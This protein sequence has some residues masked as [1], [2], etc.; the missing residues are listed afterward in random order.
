VDDAGHKTSAGFLPMLAGV[1]SEV[2][3]DRLV[4]HLTCPAE[5][6][7]LH[8][9]PSLSAD[10]PRY[11]DRGA[12]RRGSVYPQDNYAIVKGLERYRRDA[13]ALRVA[14]NH[15]TTVSHVFKETQALWENYA[16]DYIEPGSIAHPDEPLAALSAIA[17]LLET[18]FGFRVDAPQ[19]ALHWRPHLRETHGVEGLRVGGARVSAHVVEHMGQLTARLTTSEPLRLHLSGAKGDE[20]LDVRQSF[21]TSLA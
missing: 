2:Q 4:Q 10:Q 3:A 12:G 18:I 5:F 11:A 1:A 14:D 16:P 6:W 20:W 15:L 21:K 9:A 13:L 7:R 19:N 8:V 17:L